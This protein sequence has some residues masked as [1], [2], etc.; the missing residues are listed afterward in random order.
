MLSDADFDLRLRRVRLGAPS[1]P[2]DGRQKCA[3][4]S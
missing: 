1:L 3:I 2:A 4:V